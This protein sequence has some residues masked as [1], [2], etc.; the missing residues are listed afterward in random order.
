MHFSDAQESHSSIQESSKEYVTR[1]NGEVSIDSSSFY[2]YLIC[3]D[4]LPTFAFVVELRFVNR[5]VY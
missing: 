2:Y 4:V 1:M 3:I 5:Y